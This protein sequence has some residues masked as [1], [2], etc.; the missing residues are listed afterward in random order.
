MEKLAELPPAALVTFGAVLALIFGIRFLGLF[1]GQSSSPEKSAG[2]AQVAAVIVDSSAL[3]RGTAAVEALNVTLM[4]TNAI[5][6][7]HARSN[8][9]LAE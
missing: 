3:N 7:E 4:E 1:Q 6:R 8:S 5:G 9:A 2:G